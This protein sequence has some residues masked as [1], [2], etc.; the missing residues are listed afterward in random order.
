MLSTRS[1]N[2]ATLLL[3]ED[4]TLGIVQD[5]QEQMEVLEN[6]ITALHKTSKKLKMVQEE[7]NN[8]N[9]LLN[10]GIGSKQDKES[11][12]KTKKQLREQRIVLRDRLQNLSAL[13]EQRQELAQELE[14][15]QRRYGL[16]LL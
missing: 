7:I 10:S 8:L 15:L 12:R 13:Q 6:Q 11:M 2:S 3:D 1:N 4:V 5:I 14:R 16:F 9:F